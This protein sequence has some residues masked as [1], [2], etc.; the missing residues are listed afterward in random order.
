MSR[1]FLCDEFLDLSSQAGNTALS[2]TM[3]V[4]GRLVFSLYLFKVQVVCIRKGKNRKIGHYRAI[5]GTVI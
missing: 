4:G 2:V 3:Q 1:C 5:K